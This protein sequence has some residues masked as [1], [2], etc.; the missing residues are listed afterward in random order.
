MDYLMLLLVSMGCSLLFMPQGI[1]SK[2]W[3]KACKKSKNA[4]QCRDLD[5]HIN[6]IDC[7]FCKRG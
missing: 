1:Y 7:D 4:Y 6:F 2:R 3:A 5:L